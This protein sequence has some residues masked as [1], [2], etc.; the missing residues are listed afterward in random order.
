MAQKL[1]KELGLNVG[2]SS[3]ANFIGAVMSGCGWYDYSFSR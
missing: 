2:I 3:G 1:K